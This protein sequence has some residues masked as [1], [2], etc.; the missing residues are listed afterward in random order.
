[1]KIMNLH[2]KM[3]H[4]IFQGWYQKNE[5]MP[6]MTMVFVA[7]TMSKSPNVSWNDWAA[8]DLCRWGKVGE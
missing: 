4:K 2:L 1:M 8:L 6:K 5:E 3:R 7:A